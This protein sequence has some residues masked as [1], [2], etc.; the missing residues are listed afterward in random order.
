MQW[1]DYALI[2]A[3]CALVFVVMI[4]ATLVLLLVK[5]RAV[6]F[7]SWPRDVDDPPA[8]MN[9]RCVTSF[10]SPRDE[11]VASPS[12]VSWESTTTTTNKPRAVRKRKAPVAKKRAA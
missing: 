8:G 4:T 10:A 9:C 5:L 6:V 7:G 3:V 1:S 12:F 11:R 2:A